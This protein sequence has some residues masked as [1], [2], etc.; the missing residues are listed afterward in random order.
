[1]AAVPISKSLTYH[2]LYVTLFED[3]HVQNMTAA[4]AAAG[5]SLDVCDWI[6]DS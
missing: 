1:M 3:L 5:T 6:K 2:V 4:A